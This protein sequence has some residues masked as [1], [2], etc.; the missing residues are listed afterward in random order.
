MMQ[1]ISRLL[2]LSFSLIFL[3]SSCR[4]RE[5]KPPLQNPNTPK[6]LQDN[7]ES[8]MDIIYKSRSGD[9]IDEIYNDLLE[10]RP[11]LKKLE[12]NIAAYNTMEPDSLTRYS[13]YNK[14]S[15]LYYQAAG[16]Q[17][18]TITDSVLKK[19]MQEVIMASRSQYVKKIAFIN[20]MITDLG[21][22]DTSL[23]NYHA[24]LKLLV[25]LPVM[26]QFQKDELPNDKALRTLTVDKQELI[27]RTQRLAHKFN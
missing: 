5:E 22:A 11:D 21:K 15:I 9:L 14:K 17:I 2:P 24:V 10:K 26:E 12:Q 19:Q 27:H 3:F 1:P 8:N 20:K 13:K 23:N 16:M 7:K 6:A 4:H 25:T 18:N